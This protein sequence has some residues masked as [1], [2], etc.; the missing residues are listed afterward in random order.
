M[1]LKAGTKN[2][3]EECSNECLTCENKDVCTKCKGQFRE[4]KDGKC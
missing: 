4:V 3:C 1:F 2:Q